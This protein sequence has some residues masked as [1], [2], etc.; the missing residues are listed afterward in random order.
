MPNWKGTEMI[1]REKA[2]EEHRKMWRWLADYPGKDKWDY[3]IM[4]DYKCN[5]VNDCF[6]CD[7]AIEQSGSYKTMCEF[8]PLDWGERKE[9]TAE[10]DNGLYDLW[11]QCMSTDDYKKAAEIAKEIA[12]LPER[13]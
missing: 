6:L 4:T 11:T 7:Y 8:C 5:L 3:F 9:C 12:E 2:I 10:D 1:S 13:S